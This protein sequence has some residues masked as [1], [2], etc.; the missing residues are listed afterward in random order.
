[1]LPLPM[2]LVL[3]ANNDGYII[4]LTLPATRPPTFQKQGIRN[5][6]YRT[7]GHGRAGNDRVEQSQ[8]RQGN[9]QNIVNEGEEQILPDFAE[10][11][12]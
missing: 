10:R 5:D 7:H 6:R 12:P 2:K 1:M 3:L 8:R 9:A 4:R 11:R